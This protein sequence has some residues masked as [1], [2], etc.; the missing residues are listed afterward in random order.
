MVEIR[1]SDHEGKYGIDADGE[2]NADAIT[3]QVHAGSTGTYLLFTYSPS[4]TIEDGELRFT[5][6]PDW[7]PPQDTGAGR[8]RL[9]LP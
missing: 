3:R 5:V 7:S 4:Q 2:A 6:D 1:G 8:S 9:Y